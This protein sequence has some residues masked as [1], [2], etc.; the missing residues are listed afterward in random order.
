M[1]AFEALDK[2]RDGLLSLDE[3]KEFLYNYGLYQND[4]E[5]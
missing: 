5:I 3:F 1:E 2:D 4:E